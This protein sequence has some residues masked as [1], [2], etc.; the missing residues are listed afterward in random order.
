MQEL[1]VS[2]KNAEVAKTAVLLGIR[3]IEAA[4]PRIVVKDKTGEEEA[5]RFGVAAGRVFVACPD[6]KVI[7]LENLVARLKGKAKLIA[8]V[9]SAGEGALALE[10]LEL[11]ADGVL[12][13]TE[14]EN[15]LSALHRLVSEASGLHMELKEAVVTAVKQLGLGERAC[16][17]TCSLMEHGEGMLLGC[18]SQGMLL[19]QAEVE[20]NQLAAPRPFRVN[21]GAVSLYLLAPGMK[22]RYLEEITA[23]EEVL[24]VRSDGSARRAY[25]AR[26]KI[27]RRPLVIVEAEAD[28]RTA[29]VVL[30]NAETV[31]LIT[32]EGSKAVTDLKAGDIVV[33]RFENGGR[34]FG[35]A[36]PNE[37]IV[38]R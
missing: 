15:E 30:Q 2:S 16:I 12:L 23:G 37:M 20:K 13:I 33:G 25:V 19:V 31:R 27:E 29:K 7:P 3:A 26:S 8:E 11:G 5:V 36:V 6:W 32:P 38:E 17:D 34:H 9:R 35:I 18:S 4:E 21:A 10:A 1:M 24:L 28:G 22:T 14:D